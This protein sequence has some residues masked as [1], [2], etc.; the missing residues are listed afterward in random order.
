MTRPEFS[1]TVKLDQLGSAEHAVL[2]T[3]SPAECT[4]LATRF[5]LISIDSLTASVGLRMIDDC[6]TLKGR[7]NAA[8]VQPCAASAA[9]IAL[10][11]DEP[12]LIKFMSAEAHGPDAE[13]ELDA[14]DCDF[15]EHDGQMIDVGEAVAQSLALA[16]DPF[17][18]APNADTVLKAVGVKQEG[19]E[20]VGAFAGLAAL[21]DKLKQ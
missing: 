10:S 21:R 3:A 9:P 4:A 18:R 6:I 13:I 7:F 2:L 15:A 20:A 8:L 11:F 16:L 5:S 19:E 12:L 17:L 14:D 1:R